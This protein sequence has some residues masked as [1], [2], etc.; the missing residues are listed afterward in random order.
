M[1]T[2][3][4]RKKTIRIPAVLLTCL[5]FSGCITEEKSAPSSDISPEPVSI[6]VAPTTITLPLGG[7]ENFSASVTGSGNTAVNWSIKEG[8]SGGSMTSK[9]EYTAP[10]SAGTFQVTATSQVDASKS[11]TATVTVSSMLDVTFGSS[12]KVSTAIGAIDTINAVVIQSDGKIVVAGSSLNGRTTDFSL[13][14]YLTDGSL[15]RSFGSDGLVVT[16]LGSSA[17]INDIKIQSDG[18]IIAGGNTSNTSISDFVL[19]RYLI[20][21]SLD[22]TFGTNASGKVVTAVGI[23][24]DKLN[25]LALQS[26]GK[27]IAGG[28]SV[29]VPASIA[30]A[31]RNKFALARYTTSGVLDTTFD[32]DGIVT[33]AIGNKNEAISTLA[34]QSTGEIVAGGF[35]SNGSNNDFALTRYTSTGALDTTFDSDGKVTTALGSGNEEIT[36]LALQSGGEIVVAGFSS[37]GSDNDFALVRYTSV[38]ALDTSFD[39]DG[40]VITTIGSGNEAIKALAL[41]GT[42]IIVGGFSSNGTN[43]DFA[44]AQY[45][46]AGVLDTSF[47][48]DGIVTTAMGTGV[49]EINGLALQSGGE[50]VVGGFSSNGTRVDFALTRYLATGSLDTT[51]DTDG[52]VTTL[53]GGGSGEINALGIQLDG[54]IVSAGFSFGINNIKNDDFSLVRYESDG[55]I[56]PTFN[57]DGR[58]TTSLGG[59]T[60][61]DHNRIHALAIQPADQKII[62]AGVYNNSGNDDFTLARYNTDGALDTSFD[63]DG[64]VQTQINTNAEEIN[65]LALQSDGKIVVAGRSF[66]NDSIHSSTL[67]NPNDSNDLHHDDNLPNHHDIT[68]ARYLADGSLDTAFISDP[69]FD[70]FDPVDTPGIVTTPIGKGSFAEAMV[71]QSDGKIVVAGHSNS[72]TTFDFALVRYNVNGSLDTT[73]DTDGIVTTAVGPGHDFAKALAIQ[74]DGKILVAGMAFLDSTA[75]QFALV[76]YNSDGSLDTAFDTDGIVTTVIGIGSQAFS[77][78]LQTDGKILLGGFS[79]SATN[80]RDFTIARYLT[81]GSLDTTFGVNGVDISPF[82]SAMDEVHD[83]AILSDGKILAAGFSINGF[84]EDSDFH[85]ARFNP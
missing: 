29:V 37:N 85:I 19:A 35:S 46:S 11:A 83:L 2:R 18:K 8:A 58:V 53:V 45:T 49:N 26:D 56:D 63:T 27:I 20:D 82:S 47:D 10:S 22:K 16:D 84:G 23:G 25:A 33:T 70:Q 59:T 9:G 55:T 80:N 60:S 61:T 32:T 65:A 51:F 79:I 72:G 31:G 15:D 66:T 71:I 57:T 78:A 81:D 4:S 50:I 14:R 68:L 39:S 38:G 43:N 62:V 40:K 17:E 67:H 21:G 5:I 75:E 3:L 34:I 30:S 54:K 69:P 13:A 48:T 28:Y 76:R 74:T 41:S 7:T 44:V 77:I 52:K 12:G 64:I 42:N 24:D 6:S 1:G 36:A 73:F